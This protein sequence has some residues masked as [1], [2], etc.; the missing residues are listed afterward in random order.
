MQNAGFLYA[1]FTIIWALVFGYVLFL[2]RRQSALRRE[3]ELLKE[4]A[5]KNAQKE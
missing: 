2:V 5:K 3:I 1:A 4:S